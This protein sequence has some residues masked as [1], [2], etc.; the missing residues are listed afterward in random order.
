M[1]STYNPIA[2]SAIF[3]IFASVAIA[4]ATSIYPQSTAAR[5]LSIAQTSRNGSERALDAVWRLPEVQGKAREIRRLSN[6]S[7]SVKLAVESTPTRNEPFYTI[8]V[9]EDRR[10][11]IVTLYWFQ[12]ASPGGTIT[13]QDEL[14]G[15]YISLS[16]W[17]KR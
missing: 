9:F 10:D 13:V 17:R 4:G 1:S 6:G 2:R 11:R 7:V 3:L 5:E 8:R 14:T 12:V 15:E 16:E